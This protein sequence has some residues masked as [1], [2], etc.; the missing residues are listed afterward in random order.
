[1]KWHVPPSAEGIEQLQTA[2]L[3]G[4]IFQCNFNFTSRVDA[5]LKLCSQNVYF[6]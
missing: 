2:K 4:V 3:F 6:C 1:M 5:V